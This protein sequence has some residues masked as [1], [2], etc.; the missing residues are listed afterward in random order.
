MWWVDISHMDDWELNHSMRPA[1]IP[2]MLSEIMEKK[3]ITLEVIKDNNSN[4][5]YT[6]KYQENMI[7]ITIQKARGFSLMY[8][9]GLGYY[10]FHYIDESREFID[11]SHATLS[12]PENLEA[13]LDEATNLIEHHNTSAE[14]V[15]V[16]HDNEEAYS[17]VPQPHVFH[18]TSIPDL[19][20]RVDHLSRIVLSMIDLL[21]TI[22]TK[23]SEH[24]L[25]RW[26]HELSQ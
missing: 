25:E 5:D 12:N 13:K 23:V 7:N 15:M 9:D 20:T 16:N 14:H 22:T 26:K 24:D 21:E 6:V 19:E 8:M 3:H 4:Y 1:D 17:P 18:R 2:A 11:E 10:M